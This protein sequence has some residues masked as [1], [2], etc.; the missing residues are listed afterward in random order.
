M[1][2]DRFNVLPTFETLGA[3]R[4]E[5][6]KLM[7]LTISF[8]LFEG[9]GIG[10]LLPI[11]EYAEKGFFDIHSLQGQVLLSIQRI[12]DL[13]E[14]RL[15]LFTL[16]T[17]AFIPLVIRTVLQYARDIEAAKLKF[18]IATNLRRNAVDGFI[19]ADLAFLTSH[20]KGE[21]FSALTVESDRA[22]EAMAS[23]IVFVNALMLFCIYIILLF[24]LSPIL[25]LYTLPI[26][27][28][29]AFVFRYQGDT[30]TS[31]ST[32][33]S[34]KNTRFGEQISDYLNGIIRI[35]MRAQEAKTTSILDARIQQIMAS[36]FNIEKLRVLVEIGIYPVLIL[37]AFYVLYIAVAHLEM[38]LA[39]LGLF[40]FILIRLL[41]QL[42]LMNSMWT[43]MHGCLA[44][45]HRLNNLIEQATLQYEQPEGDSRFVRLLQGIEFENVSFRYPHNFSTDFAIRDIHFFIPKGSITAIVGRSGAGKTTIVNLLIR[46]YRPQ[47]GNI[48]IDDIP[49]Q[50][51]AQSSFRKKIAYVSQEPFLFHD[52]VSNNINFGVTPPISSAE[53]F[54]IL[55]QTYCNDFVKK[56]EHGLETVVGERGNRLSQGQR[57]RLAIASALAIKPEILILDEPT[58]A[59]DS[60]SE[61]AIQETL[62]NLKEYLTI[63]V[64]AHRFSTISHADQI[65]L[66][67]NGML[68]ETGRHEDLLANS[69]LYKSL[70]KTQMI[71]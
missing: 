52:T 10:I 14:G 28:I 33:V 40:M 39:G 25:A 35:K 7:I 65:L 67:D 17:L 60:E 69:P 2:P 37:S 12:F 51:Y 30:A 15:T 49:L 5:V 66:M 38:S 23:R 27:L 64:I 41:P 63:I 36:L 54:S 59:L 16:L 70:F 8:A 53:I 62:I 24:I 68:L 1:R 21:L 20:A 3:S 46:F 13:K 6:L 43:H 61:R 58:S 11:L 32:A 42:T 19:H 9:I 48:R 26:F 57:Q 47:F 4:N 22:A 55:N 71:V 50:R 34:E 45:F 18:K 56:L 29:V 31:L 44:S